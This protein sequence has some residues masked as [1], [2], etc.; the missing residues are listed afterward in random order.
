MPIF[1]R[2]FQKPCISATTYLF[3][4]IS[5][6][7]NPFFWAQLV[8]VSIWPNCRVVNLG[9]QNWP[10]MGYFAVYFIRENTI[11]LLFWGPKFATRQFGQMPTL[12]NW[13]QKKGF[14]SWDMVFQNP[15]RDFYEK[16]PSSRNRLRH[17]KKNPQSRKTAI[18][19]APPRFQA[20]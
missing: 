20:L 4:L 7:Q 11:F 12:T 19:A 1:G 15:R 10:N 18:S 5:Q 3:P 8:K 6:L 13:A 16:A 2:F 14:W 9:P 17:P